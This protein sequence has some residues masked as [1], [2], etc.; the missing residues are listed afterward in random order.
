[1]FKAMMEGIREETVEQVFA[2]VARFDAAA[3]RAEADGTAEAARAVAGSDGTAVA[4][5][6]APHRS[7]L[8]D[9]GRAS[10]NQRVTYSAPSEDGSGQSMTRSEARRSSAPQPGGRAA[11]NRA[12]RAAGGRA[13]AGNRAQSGGQAQTGNWAQSGG[14]AQAGNRAQSGG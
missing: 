12:G 5:L 8:G 6:S 9:T 1:M 10:M 11:G 4:G 13:Q 7:V 2:N 3:A 14:Q